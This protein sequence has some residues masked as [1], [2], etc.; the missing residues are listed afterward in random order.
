MLLIFSFFTAFRIV[1][2]TRPDLL[3]DIAAI[4]GAWIGSA[5]GY[6]FGSRPTETMLHSVIELNEQRRKELENEIT[7]SKKHTAEIYGR[8]LDNEQQINQAE[9][10]IRNWY[11]NIKKQK[12]KLIIS[13]KDMGKILM[14]KS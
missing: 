5:I 4:W 9:S 14:I 13:L 7:E 8:I 10:E 2:G 1:M 12:K 11:I 3:K 6:F